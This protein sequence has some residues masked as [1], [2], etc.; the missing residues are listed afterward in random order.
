MFL[1]D[2]IGSMFR[3]LV[4]LIWFSSIHA[5]ERQKI[6][7]NMIVKNESQ[8][9]KRS[10]GSVKRLIDY[11]VIVDTGSEDGTQEIIKEFMKEIPGELHESPWVNFEHNRNEA[12]SLAQ[13][14]GDYVLFIDADE[15]FIYDANFEL[16][17]LDQDSYMVTIDHSNTRYYR[18]LLINNHLDWRWV[19]V[20]HEYLTAPN[21]MTEEILPGVTNIYR[22][23]GCRSQ[24]P[25]KFLNDAKV[26]E[27]A[28]KKDPHNSRYV[29]YL[30]QSYKDG[31]DHFNAL[32]NYER[33]VEMGGWDQ[34]VFWAKYQIALM[35]EVLKM[36][37]EE[38][39]ESYIDAY[40]FRPTRA[41]PLCHL[42]TFYRSQENHFLAYL[43]ANFAL[44]IEKPND[45]LMVEY[46]VYDYWLKM[47]KAMAA[48]KIGK[49]KEALK[50][51]VMLLDDPKFPEYL[52]SLMDEVLRTAIPSL[53]SQ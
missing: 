23:E 26:F 38:V 19:G 1:C 15:E 24:D 21:A 4:L 33:R 41:E 11:W 17:F 39:I 49:D 3:I 40:T 2:S 5:S 27:E 35:K 32:K 8:V 45:I 30:A 50:E 36:P 12:L 51:S 44:S 46:Y 47:E 16:P 34:E 14:K 6:C 25:N 7:L 52:H 31:G 10:L 20:L 22:S 28:L 48:S 53:R 43:V 37:P 13:G 18:R 42:A 9:I 29:F